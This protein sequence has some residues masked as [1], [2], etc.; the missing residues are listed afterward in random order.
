MAIRLK[1]YAKNRDKARAFAQEI[2]TKNIED[3]VSQTETDLINMEFVVT[4][5]RAR[6]LQK[7][8]TPAKVALAI[9]GALKTEVIVNGNK[10]RI[11]PA[12]P[13]PSEFTLHRCQGERSFIPH[14]GY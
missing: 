4:P 9:K 7:D 13:T 14:G 6:M 8:L 2:E 12:A 10:L 3:V 5:D 11:K 1:K